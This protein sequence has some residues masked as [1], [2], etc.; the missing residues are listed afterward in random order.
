MTNPAYECKKK[1]NRDVF[2]LNSI[3]GS[4]GKDGALNF[5]GFLGLDPTNRSMVKDPLLGKD[6]SSNFNE[7]I[8]GNLMA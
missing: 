1:R 6:P 3:F 5:T 8:L 7:N 4:D 2:L